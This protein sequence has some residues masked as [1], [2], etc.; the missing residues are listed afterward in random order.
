MK[1]L[2]V[3]AVVAVAFWVWRNNRQSA[4]VESTKAARKP[5]S[6][7]T[8]A[9]PQPMLQCAACGVHLPAGEALVGRQGSY[10]SAAHRAQLEG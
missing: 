5:A 4:K 9:E 7:G 2:L 6:Q 3:L 8:L 10:C 1:Y